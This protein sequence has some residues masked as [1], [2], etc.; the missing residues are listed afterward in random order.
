MAGEYEPFDIRKLRV[1]YIVVCLLPST[2]FL[3]TFVLWFMMHGLTPAEIAEYG[4]DPSMVHIV[5]FGA[6]ALASLPAGLLVRRLVLTGRWPVA[7]AYGQALTREQAAMGRI[8]LAMVYGM[9]FP[10]ISV[11]FGFVL[12]FMAMSWT[13]FLPFIAY[14][15]LGWIIMFPRPSQLRDW[16]ERQS[17]SAALPEM[18][19]G[20]PA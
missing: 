16:Y 1:S 15:I 5:L 11:L 9:S 18:N 8:G 3:L 14:A 19:V 20:G 4:E 13:Y 2:L 6:L 12:G 7:A 17:G 10:D